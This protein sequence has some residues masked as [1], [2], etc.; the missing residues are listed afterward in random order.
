MKNPGDLRIFSPR[1]QVILLLLYVLGQERRPEPK[2]M[3]IARLRRR[4]LFA[5]AE[6]D[7]RPYPSNFEKGVYEPRW[8]T[9]VAFARQD[10]VDSNWMSDRKPDKWRI[11]EE[12][13]TVLGAFQQQCSSGA[14]DVR[15]GYLWTPKFKRLMVPDYQPSESDAPRPKCSIYDDIKASVRW[16]EFS[17][18]IEQLEKRFGA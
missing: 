3:I 4:Y 18:L 9:L 1:G 11:T 8:I 16:E 13:R 10:C 15:H 5:F 12:G 6:E 17:I 14:L 7:K 2:R